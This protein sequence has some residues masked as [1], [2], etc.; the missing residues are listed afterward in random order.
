MRRSLLDYAT[1]IETYA[2]RSLLIDGFDFERRIFGGI[3]Q[4][5]SSD[6]NRIRRDHAIMFKWPNPNALGLYLTSKHSVGVREKPDP[7]EVYGADF[8]LVSFDDILKFFVEGWWTG[9]VRDDPD[10]VRFPYEIAD[11]VSLPDDRSAA[12]LGIESDRDEIGYA[13]DAHV[14]TQSYEETGGKES[15][16]VTSSRIEGVAKSRRTSGEK[17]Q[18]AVNARRRIANK[19]T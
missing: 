15:K 19:S 16:P 11:Y 1:S 18:A 7:E 17:R 6:Q 3:I 8:S 2:N 4:S 5:I 14:E 9:V 12:L 10:A 13:N